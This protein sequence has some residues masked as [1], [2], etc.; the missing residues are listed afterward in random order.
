MEAGI[1]QATDQRLAKTLGAM[2]RSARRKQGLN[3]QQLSRLSGI[4]IATLSHLENGNRDVKLSTIERAFDALQL[5]LA[6]SHS[7]RFDND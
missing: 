6:D 4:G 1:Q 3:L 7:I 5:T 2:I